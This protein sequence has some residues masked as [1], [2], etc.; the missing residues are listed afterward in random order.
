MRGILSGSWV[1]GMILILSDFTQKEGTNPGPYLAAKKAAEPSEAA[2]AFTKNKENRKSPI[3]KDVKPWDD[4]TGMNKLEKAVLS[5][6]VEGLL[7][8]ASKLVLVGYGKQ[9]MLTIIDE[10]VS[11]DTLMEKR[12]TV[13]PINEYV[14]SCDIIALKKI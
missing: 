13:E 10:L 4:E 8:G 5:F 9:I 7:W 1:V 11:V 6:D 3:F 14:Q 12:L 2:E